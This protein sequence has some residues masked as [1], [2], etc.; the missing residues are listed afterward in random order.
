MLFIIMIKNPKIYKLFRKI[1]HRISQ[2]KYFSLSQFDFFGPSQVRLYP[3]GYLCNHACP[4]CWRSNN[5]SETEKRKLIKLEKQNL[6]INEYEKI[7]QTLPP[8][9]TEIELVGGGEPLLYPEIKKL[10]SLIKAYGLTGSLI[11]NGVLLSENIAKVLIDHNWEKVRISF[12]AHNKEIYKKLNGA[13]TFDQVLSN[14]RSY[15]KLKKESGKDKQCQLETL[16]VIQK[17]NYQYIWKFAKLF[18]KIGVD[19]INFDAI[20]AHNDKV[21]PNKKELKVI[22]TQLKKI[23]KNINIKNNSGEIARL[24]SSHPNIGQNK[25][26]KL[27]YFKN[28]SCVITSQSMIINSLGKV[29][30]CCFL[31]GDGNE[32]ITLGSIRKT[33]NLWEIWLQK[34]YIAV[35]KNLGKGKFYKICVKKCYYDLPKR[36]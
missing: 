20:L 3:I 6:K 1:F 31:D 15:I 24:Y 32:A 11:T 30:P 35:R 19:S 5:I 22:I 10:V 13:E 4:M 36:K 18:E 28:K 26:S 7:F 23:E 12:H 21:K 25:I 27:N 17:D 33:P 34:Q 2:S 8:N 14:I 29:H 16:F 9:T